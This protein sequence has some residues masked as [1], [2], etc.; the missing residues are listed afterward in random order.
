MMT[1]RIPTMVKSS[2]FDWVLA[3]W[4]VKGCGWR[5]AAVERPRIASG[6]RLQVLLDLVRFLAVTAGPLALALF[7]GGDSL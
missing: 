3:P 4:V 6:W 1:M 7:A 2:S 5:S